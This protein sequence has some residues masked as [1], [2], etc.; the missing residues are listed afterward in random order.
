MIVCPLPMRQKIYDAMGKHADKEGECRS[1]EHSGQGEEW[2]HNDKRMHGNRYGMQCRVVQ[3]P[4]ECLPKSGLR[5][6]G[7]IVR[8]KAQG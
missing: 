8:Y 7:S 4:M 3:E 1:V 2:T 5:H 6:D